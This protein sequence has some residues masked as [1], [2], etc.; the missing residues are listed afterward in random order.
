MADDQAIWIGI[1]QNVECVLLLYNE[2]FVKPVLY[3]LNVWNSYS[4]IYV[5]KKRLN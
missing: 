3:I 4:T 2:F 5:V 1:N